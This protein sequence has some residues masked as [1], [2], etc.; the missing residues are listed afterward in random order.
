MK[1][2]EQQ[3]FKVKQQKKSIQRHDVFKEIKIKK[4]FPITVEIKNGYY[5]IESKMNNYE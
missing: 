2:N 4:S 1:Y 5:I 3:K